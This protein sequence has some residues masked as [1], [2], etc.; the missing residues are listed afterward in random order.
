MKRVNNLYVK[1]ISY[2]NLKEAIHEVCKTHRWDRH[3]H[4]NKMVAW[5]ESDIESRIND[6]KY[7]LENCYEPSPATHKRI[8]D[9]SASKWRDIYKPKIWPDQC[10]HHAVIQVLQPVFMHGMD[11]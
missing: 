3:H 5:I 8:Y 4:K 10:I 6:L 7:I 9:H 11:Y 1:L 2:D